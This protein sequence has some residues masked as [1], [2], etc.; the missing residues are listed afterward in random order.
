M[1]GCGPGL[2]E[3]ILRT[4]IWNLR[5]QPSR[6]GG[7]SSYLSWDTLRTRKGRTPCQGWLTFPAS[8][9]QEDATS[10]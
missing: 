9:V 2:G 3:A 8:L 6:T 5:P 1:E 7:L 10:T 4:G